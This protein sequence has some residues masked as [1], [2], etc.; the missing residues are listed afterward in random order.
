[1]WLP[2]SIRDR[3]TRRSAQALRRAIAELPG[4][5]RRAMLAAAESE[6]LII[7]AYTDRFGH[8]CPMLA[9]HRRGA[10]TCVRGFPA[11]WDAFGRANRPRTA[12]DRELE[13]LRALLQE[14]LTGRID[15]HGLAISASIREESPRPPVG[16]PGGVGPA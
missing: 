4:A 1:M 7:G 8:P 6:E 14:S 12:T 16:A 15:P 3:R 5:T 10:R 13:I 11:A 2:S 9:A